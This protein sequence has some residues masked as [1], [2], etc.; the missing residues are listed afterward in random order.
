MA[1]LFELQMSAQELFEKV[2]NHLLKQ[3]AKSYLTGGQFSAC[4]YRGTEERMC[5]AGILIPDE[6][7]LRK[8][9]CFRWEALIAYDNFPKEHYQLIVRLQNVHDTYGVPLWRE[10]LIKVAAEFKLD[11]KFLTL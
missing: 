6:V 11:A 1:H 3:G 2:A 10:Q 5:A 9:E 4:A 8:F 7:Y